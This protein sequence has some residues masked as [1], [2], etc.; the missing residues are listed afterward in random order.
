MV[1]SLW[2]NSALIRSVVK[3]EVEGRYKG[4]MPG[5]FWL[6]ANPIFMFLFYRFVFSVVFKAR[7][8]TS[9]SDS[10]NRIALVLFAG[11]MFF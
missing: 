9:G 5:I 1:A 10:K 11:R 3:R 4:S 7:W 8:A 6:L 2:R